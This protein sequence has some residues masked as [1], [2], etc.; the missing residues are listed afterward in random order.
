VDSGLQ[1]IINSSCFYMSQI[2]SPRFDAR[3]PKWA[4]GRPQ[5]MKRICILLI[6][7]S[8][9]L[10]YTLFTA[11][12]KAIGVLPLKSPVQTTL[13]GKNWH[14]TVP[15]A[16]HNVQD[17]EKLIS[18]ESQGVN[19]TRPDSDGRLS[20]GILQYHLGPL[21]TEQSST[22]ELFSRASGLKGSPAVPADAIRM[23]DWAIS[24]GLGPH[25]TC[26]HIEKL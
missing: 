15:F 6:L 20:I 1:F 21:N 16:V 7:F 8:L 18:C 12:A 22:W 13:E 10:T 2:N 9:I 23:T 19:I 26:W 14:Y 25:W 11:P 17:I 24:H 4:W 3:L 5:P